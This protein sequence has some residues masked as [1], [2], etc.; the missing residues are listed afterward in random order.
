MVVTNSLTSSREKIMAVAP[1]RLGAGQMARS[2]APVLT[3]TKR[4]LNR[5]RFLKAQFPT[6]RSPGVEI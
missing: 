1:R 3:L 2:R 6:E 4:Q 5:S